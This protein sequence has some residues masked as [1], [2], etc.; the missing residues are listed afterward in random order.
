MPGIGWLVFVALVFAYVLF[1]GGPG[2]V[3][4]VSKDIGLE[5]SDSLQ[6]TG[7]WN[8]RD[9]SLGIAY[10]SSAIGFEV[11]VAADGI[12]VE[13]SSSVATAA[14]AATSSS[15]F[16]ACHISRTTL[17]VIGPPRV[18]SQV[19]PE[20]IQVWCD[21]EDLVQQIFSDSDLCERLQITLRSAQDLVEIDPGQVY[22]ETD[23]SRFDGEYTALFAAWNAARTFVE[24]LG[25]GIPEDG[26]LPVFDFKQR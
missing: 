25:P 22:V 2:V 17:F 26:A 23:A 4:R 1:S 7:R 9:V 10:R 15:R 14:I 16:R 6:A 18:E 11:T 19:V 3:G 21:A 13:S 5:E 20:T 12:G 24:H 8:G